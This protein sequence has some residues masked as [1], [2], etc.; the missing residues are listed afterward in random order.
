[1]EKVSASGGRT[2]LINCSVVI[3]QGEVVGLAGLEGSGQGVFLRL[4]AGLK[5]PERGTI[6]VGNK[7]MTGR[8]HHA[9]RTLG[10][11]FLPA[12][13]LEEGLIPGLTITEHFALRPGKGIL[14]PWEQSR[15]QAMES[16]ERF[17]IMGRPS[18]GVESLSGGNQQRLLLALMPP[19]PLLLLLEQPTRG[20]DVESAGWVWRNL[21]DYA[22]KGASVVFCSQELEEILQV[23]NRVLVFYNGVVVKDVMVCDI[24][25]HEIGQAIAGKG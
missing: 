5:R 7:T 22:A 3:R 2:G 16:V 19:N 14:V 10:V 11:T 25:L 1:M 21:I 13:R 12:A 20:L 15:R 24:T 23:A 9:F 8:D 4:A 17:R 18:S 6:R